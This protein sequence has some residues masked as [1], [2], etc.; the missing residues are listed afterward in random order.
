MVTQNAVHLRAKIIRRRCVWTIN[1]TLTLS[2][3]FDGMIYYYHSKLRAIEPSTPRLFRRRNAFLDRS[4]C[5]A[6]MILSPLNVRCGM[7]ARGYDEHSV[8]GDVPR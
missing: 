4:T 3:R 5:L 1:G 6:A 7:V 2:V 8:I